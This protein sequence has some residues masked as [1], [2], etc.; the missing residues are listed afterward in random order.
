MSHK[1]TPALLRC[2]K[3]RKCIANSDCLINDLE[4]T[5]FK[6]G[7]D[8]S[9]D[10]GSCNIWHL[11]AEASPDWIKREIEKV[12]WATGKLNCPYCRARLGAFNFVDSTK[13]SCGRL[14]VI[15]LCKSKIDVDVVRIQCPF[16][17]TSKLH[18][19]FDKGTRHG[20]AKHLIKSSTQTFSTMDR[21][22]AARGTLVDALCLEVPAL[23]KNCE[24][25]G[26]KSLF[27]LNVKKYN[28]ASKEKKKSYSRN[29]F[30][31]KSNSLDLDIKEHLLPEFY[32][33]I[34][35]TLNVKQRQSEVPFFNSDSVSSNN[36]HVNC[37]AFDIHR[38]IA[39]FTVSAENCSRVSEPF[40]NRTTPALSGLEEN[41]SQHLTALSITPAASTP[42]EE[43]IMSP[44]DLPT[45]SM[46]PVLPRSVTISQRLNKREINKLKSLR[47]RQKKR[48]KWLHGQKQISTN[49]LLLSFQ[50]NIFEE[51]K[52]FREEIVLSGPYQ[53]AIGCSEFLEVS[54][55]ALIL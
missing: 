15:R 44:V 48:E 45:Q 16:L 22:I 19:H 46:Q 43:C 51:N 53:A 30:H 2:W 24:R 18:T 25:S 47:R 28:S 8:L 9:T 36:N 29:M 38:S 32:K 6:D 35:G 26:S 34:K 4:C 21:L 12:H 10:Q 7:F 27:T 39:S 54:E 17:S 14:A 33:N 50:M 23:D 20:I 42:R 31:R 37:H 1:G 40:Y 52:V 3:C 41:D 55:D 11:E 13:C 5:Q 49:L